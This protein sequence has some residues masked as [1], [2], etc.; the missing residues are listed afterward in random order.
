MF[1]Q[2]IPGAGQQAQ[3]QQVYKYQSTRGETNS[4]GKSLF[5]V[6]STHVGDV[7]LTASDKNGNSLGIP[8]LIIHFTPPQAP[9]LVTTSQGS[10]ILN[11]GFGT[12][13]FTDWT[14]GGT[15]APTI[16]T[17]HVYDSPYSAQLGSATPSGAPTDSS[18]ME[19]LTIPT[20][21]NSLSFA[22]QLVNPNA[23]AHN[24]L[25]VWVRDS[26]GEGLFKLF[27]SSTNS[28]GWQTSALTYIQKYRG[29][30]VQIYFTL[31]QD[32][33]ANPAYVYLDEIALQ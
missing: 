1:A 14:N 10:A 29:N 9:A 28:A 12:G 25:E 11:G 30:T 24:D 18:I 4:S 33:S 23:D 27:S 21:A 22:Y 19:T 6:R 26:S 17:T 32:G 2:L 8:P 13:N 20:A 31:H 7:T 5:V 16:N 3:I 15:T